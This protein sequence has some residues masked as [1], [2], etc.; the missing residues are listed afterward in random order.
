MDVDVGAHE[1]ADEVPEGSLGVDLHGKFVGLRRAG[2]GD[3]G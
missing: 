2:Q 3:Q 1:I